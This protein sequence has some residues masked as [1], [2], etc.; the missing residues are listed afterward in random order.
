MAAVLVVVGLGLH[1]SPARRFVL[2]QAVQILADRFALVVRADSLQ[3]NVLTLRVRLV[4]VSVSAAASPDAPFFAADAVDLSLPPS[5]LRAG[6]RVERLGVENGRVTITRD[7]NGALNLPAGRGAA[8]DEPGVLPIDHIDA[9]ALSIAL[10]DQPRQLS[11][12]LPALTLDV[13]H[14]GGSIRLLE[15]GLLRQAQQTTSIARLEGGLAF[16]GRTAHL[17]SLSTT[18]SAGDVTVDGALGL[19]A[20]APRTDVRVRGT[21]GVAEILRWA[22][23]D[24]GV[25]GTVSFDGAIA[26]PFTSPVA[27][28]RLAS[29]RLLVDDLALTE[30]AADVGADSDRVRIDRVAAR[31]LGGSVRAAGRHGIADGRS[32]FTIEWSEL[33]TAA[34]QRALAGPTRAVIAS[35]ATG[36]ATLEGSISAWTGWTFAAQSRLHP[37]RR[38]TGR[39]PVDALLTATVT[40]GAW[41][42]VTRGTVDG[43]GLD[44]TL[45]GA[46]DS[47]MSRST[48]TG[49]IAVHET[50]ARRV[51][52]IL[53]NAGVAG[54]ADAPIESGRLGIH[55][56]VTG[57]IGEPHIRATALIRDANVSTLSGLDADIVAA[58]GLARVD[59]DARLRHGQGNVARVVGSIAPN[60]RRLDADVS[61]SLVDSAALIPDERVAGRL[62][63]DVHVEG[64]LDELTARGTAAISDI[65]YAGLHLDRADAALEIDPSA[66]RLNLVAPEI[67]LIGRAEVTRET[68]EAAIE[69]EVKD[70]SL[71]RLTRD[72]EARQRIA[73]T[74]TLR[75][76]GRV[77]LDNWRTGTAVLEI[78]DI[79]ARTGDLAIRTTQ[80]GRLSYDAGAISI[81][82]LEGE[83]GGARLLVAGRLP[84][85]VPLVPNDASD[86]IRASLTGEMSDLL[87]AAR[88][89]GLQEVPELS[90]HGTVAVLAQMTGAL[91]QPAVAA[92]F[93]LAA[94]ELAFADLP[95]ARSVALRGRIA[96]GRIDLTSATATWQ[97]SRFAAEARMPLRLLER[98]LPPP[99][100]TALPATQAPASLDVRI[101]SI[102]PR[103][104]APFMDASS[105]DQLEGTIDASLHL[106]AHSLDVSA[107]EG[108]VRL[109][110]FETRVA[111]LPIAQREPTRLAVGDGMVRVV[112]WE[113]AGQGASLTVQGDVRLADR[114]TAL[115]AAARLD[116]R[117][118]TPFVG[119]SGFTLA[120]TLAPRVAIVG[121][122]ASPTLDGE[123]ALAGGEIRLREPRIVASGL[124]AFAVMTPA[125]GRVTSLDGSVNG[126]TLSGDGT[127]S[128]ARDTPWSLE[129]RGQVAGMGL[130]FPTGL[131]SELDAD[132]AVSLGDT[133]AGTSGRVTGQITVVRSTYRQPLAVVTALLTA[134]RAE[135]VAA[136]ASSAVSSRIALNVGVTTD[137]DVRVDNN[138][139]RLQLAGDLRVV[140]T[141]AAPA[142]S[143]RALLREGGQLFLGRNVY[144]IEEEGVVDFVNPQTIEPHLRIEATTRAGGHDIELVLAGTPDEPDVSLRSLTAPELG[145]AD[146]ASLLLTGRLLEDVPGAE[147]RIVGEQV[148]AYVSG[149]VLG[150]AGRAIGFDTIRL[151]AAPSPIRRDPAAVAAE[152]DPISRLT[153][154]KTFGERVELTYSQSLRNGGASTWIVDYRPLR[155]VN[156]RFV[157]DDDNLRAYEFR[158]DVEVGGG[159]TAAASRARGR[160]PRITAIDLRGTTPLADPAM[161]EAI[162]IAPGDEFE[163]SQWQRGRER[164]EEALWR[165]GF[166]EARV[167][168]SRRELVSG[169]ELTF[170]MTAGPRTVIDVSGFDLPRATRAAIETAWTQNVFDDFL[171]DEVAL[172]VRRDMRDAG[173]LEPAVTVELAGGNEKTLTISIVP[174]QRARSRQVLV[175][176]GDDRLD[177]DLERWISRQ[178]LR[179]LAWRDP[180]A[181]ALRMTDELLARGYV[182]ASVTARPPR[183][184][185]STTVFAFDV[186]PGPRYTIARVQLPG[187]TVIDADALGKAVDL[188]PGTAYDPRAVEAARARLTR[189]YR[190]EG[191]A[192]ARVDVRPGLDAA[193]RTA[194]IAFD[195]DPGPRDVLRAIEVR[196]NRAVDGDVIERT[197]DLAVGEPLAAD[198]WLAARGRLFDTALFRRVDVAAEP[199]A[200]ATATERPVQ[201]I[202]TVQEWPALR[203]R[204]GFQLSEE[205]PERDVGG[206]ALA[207]GLSADVTRRTLFGRA[208]IVGAA[209]ELQPR[210][211]LARVFANAPRFAGREIESLF[212]VERGREE[213]AAA[214]LVTDR[215]RLSWEQRVQIATPFRLSYSYSIERN[216][217]FDTSPL[218]PFAPRSGVTIDVSRV[219][220]SAIFDTRDD[221]TDASRGSLLSLNVDYA[222]PT[223]GSDVSFV[224]Q[225]A[226]AYHFRP[227]RALTLASAA[228][229]GTVAP[230]GTPALPPSELF[231]AGGPRTVRGVADD[232]L[233]PVN[234]VGEPAGGQAL[235]VLNQE[236][237]FPIVRWF[238]GVAFFDA[239]G[240]FPTPSRIDLGDITGAFGTGVRVSTPF[241]LLRLDVAQAVFG[242]RQRPVR[243]TFGIG[244]TF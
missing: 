224:R 227:W 15:P 190:A 170:E 149:D 112:S 67:A 228:R 71:E 225:L 169:V 158:H 9:P 61:A 198:A 242:E 124:N 57:T 172:I 220:G 58:G 6:F 234:R 156:V 39:L 75:G 97:D 161:R 125:G 141:V 185:G 106:E 159:R 146:V 223:L 237:R 26:G 148:L 123:L 45:R 147:G 222:P 93:D 186:D 18:T 59:V 137:D 115:L 29:S 221:P 51:Q 90:G 73:G 83:L 229:I 195:V 28:L 212:T 151:G 10:V 60:A 218:D 20:L 84:F 182:D 88:R 31:L 187:V 79:D 143:G 4:D 152:A 21:V 52:S 183:V 24:R 116:L 16:D 139:G 230:R 188:A 202:A 98:Y 208:I 244:Q 101:Q 40:N 199:S 23:Q 63:L 166:R 111:G 95:P 42:F 41:Q 122:L 69:L 54:A 175:T 76:H 140:G 44:A 217:T 174:G 235:V 135:R 189:A 144:T 113:W 203:M 211:R 196:G 163:L 53:E 50:D 87:D 68:R 118:L 127:I 102:T 117:T 243:W 64:P 219:T 210:E 1:S 201:A 80:P 204:Y 191:F 110:R 19:I 133:P 78:L 7:E 239:G 56:Q 145:E 180:G 34:L 107:I 3:Y 12:I 35:S 238:R 167:T 14:A 36:S 179:D 72:T 17:R 233:G 131:R 130:E 22:G 240:V 126:G 109:D 134:M 100:V 162:G 48:V 207:P 215:T 178:G 5:T 142:L 32:A 46:L 129:L 177:R 13:R 136:V 66:A 197:L 205:R 226:Q 155:Q 168:T 181:L 119:A 176:A 104:L 150:V 184:D 206:R 171:R 216:R 65:Q 27:R 164:L 47:R 86:A 108:Q 165:A 193:A 49:D 120:G 74:I 30:V 43:V 82:R 33:D 138:V 11:L 231:F 103:V 2:R 154:G 209:A 81:S 173:F 213:I 70:A 200:E 153:F 105:L 89:A 214:S 160:E 85:E 62:D 38:G 25:A 37:R 241:A 91:A 55:T 194:T 128:Y 92:D 96:D 8:T 77:P 236:V 157:S 114:E 192:S 232:S 94:G 132:V 121:P 99:L